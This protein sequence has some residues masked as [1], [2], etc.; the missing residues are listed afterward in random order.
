[1]K[2]LLELA[3]YASLSLG[4]FYLFALVLRAIHSVL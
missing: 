4:L 2:P 3:F 1:M